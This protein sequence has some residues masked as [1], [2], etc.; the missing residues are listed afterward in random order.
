VATTDGQDASHQLRLR[1]RPCEGGVDGPD[2]CDEHI[3]GHLRRTS[4]RIG[5]NADMRLRDFYHAETFEVQV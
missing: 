5:V 2:I 1:K 4:I 3:I